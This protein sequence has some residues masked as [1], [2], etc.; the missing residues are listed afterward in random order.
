MTFAWPGQTSSHVTGQLSVC[1]RPA[2]ATLRPKICITHYFLRVPIERHL[3]AITDSVASQMLTAFADF[4]DE[5]VPV[6]VDTAR[7]VE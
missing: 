5:G 6:R 7:I 1:T 2:L 3:F 4:H